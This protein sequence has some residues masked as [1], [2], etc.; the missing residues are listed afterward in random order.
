[1]I[2]F[3]LKKIGCVLSASAMLFYA[4]AAL[5]VTAAEQTTEKN[6]KKAQLSAYD[7]SLSLVQYQEV[8]EAAAEKMQTV[9]VGQQ[10][11]TGVIVT[12]GTV[13]RKRS[14]C[15]D[16]FG[17]QCGTR[18]ICFYHIWVW[19]WLRFEPKWCKFLCYLWWL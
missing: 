1:M 15:C 8:D 16:F 19:S 18:T 7:T 9:S 17:Y 12:S 10:Q 13:G 3:N 4:A 5:P 6:W 11:E 14:R 2:S